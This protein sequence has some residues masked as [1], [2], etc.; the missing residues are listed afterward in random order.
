MAPRDKTLNQIIG[1]ADAG[2][3]EGEIGRCGNSAKSAPLPGA[4]AEIAAGFL[5]GMTWENHTRSGWHIDHIVPCAA[6]DLSDPAQQRACFHYTNLQP[7]WA[8][9]NLK[10][11]NKLPEEI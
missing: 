8:K 5:P 7:L 10:K 4:E 2:Y 1:I 3:G 11:S 6:F 9:T